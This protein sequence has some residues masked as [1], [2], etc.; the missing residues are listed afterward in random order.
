MWH[1]SGKN[2]DFSTRPIDP[3]LAS[4]GRRLRGRYTIGRA[5]VSPELSTCDQQGREGP[6]RAEADDGQA[7]DKEAGESLG[8][9]NGRLAYSSAARGMDRYSSRL[10]G[11]VKDNITNL[12]VNGI[13]CRCRE[14]IFLI[15]RQ[16]PV[17]LTLSL[18][19][20]LSSIELLA[21]RETAPSCAIPTY[22][23]RATRRPRIYANAIR[24][25][26]KEGG[27]NPAFCPLDVVFQGNSS[28]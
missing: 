17:L 23:K 8:Q 12:I 16:L 9:K 25:A 22:S 15:F 4:E 11:Q 1:F 19:G 3:C 5:N 28:V 18:M 6:S 10:R 2:S 21:Q 24:Q 20:R 26:S 27:N 14:R 13:I 7:A